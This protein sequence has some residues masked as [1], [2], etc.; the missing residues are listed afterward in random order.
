[1]TLD[2]D[3][4]HKEAYFQLQNRIVVENKT[5]KYASPS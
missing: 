1:M 3:L 5:V 2:R 4:V